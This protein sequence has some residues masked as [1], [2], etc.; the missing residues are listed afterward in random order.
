MII[1]P[2]SLLLSLL[3]LVL[4]TNPLLAQRI[5]GGF[6]MFNF[7]DNSEGNDTYRSTVTYAGTRF[8]PTLSLSTND[9][10][11][12]I[13]GGYNF[14]YEFG[15]SELSKGAVE[16]YYKYQSPTLRILF[17][18]FPRTLM[19]E[20]MPEY[21]ICDSIRY[22]RPEMAGFDFLYT[23][24]NG[25]LE[26]F[27]DWIQKRAPTEREQ[28][29]IGL[30]TRF[31]FAKF[32][33]GMEANM[34]HYALE[35]DGLALGHSIHEVITAHPYIGLLLAKPAWLLSADLRGGM[36]MQA[37]RDRE[38]M[39]WHVPVGFIFDADIRLWRFSL[40]ETFYAGASQQ[41]FGN[42][43]FGKY[44]WGDT[45]TQS[46]CYSR[47]DLAYDIVQHKNISLAAKLAFNFT[48]AGMQWHQMLTLRIH[49]A[50]Q[51]PHPHHRYK[52]E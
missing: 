5:G 26:L 48:D 14:L 44:Y 29:M 12:Q 21:L 9:S 17:G 10:L 22:F 31:R 8:T 38:D 46:K 30:N 11:H 15:E 33:L 3:L 27:L 47:T 51:L 13:V 52:T 43:G 18:S 28:F 37:D 2:K 40:H 41:Y 42:R 23:A 7:F 49:L 36:L 6:D 45:F 32:Q 25:H 20:Q 16:V 50:S 34:Y 35:D 39:K 1:S 24:R 4:S 19:H